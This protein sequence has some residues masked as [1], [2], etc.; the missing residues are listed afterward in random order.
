MLGRVPVATVSGL[1][2]GVSGLSFLGVGL[3]ARRT[4]ERSLVREHI[5]SVTDAKPQ[6]TTVRSAAAA[7]SLAEVIRSQALAAAGGKTYAETDAYVGPDGAPTSDSASALKDERTGAPV[8][9]PDHALWIQATALETALMQA[10]LAF[11]IADLSMA[12]GGTLVVAGAG[13][14]ATGAVRR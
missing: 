8:E 6:S 11:R 3:W 12:V 10:Y 1:V 4:V 14:A 7:R 9:H 2:V 13:I 5:V